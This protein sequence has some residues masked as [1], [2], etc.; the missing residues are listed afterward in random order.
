MSEE[1]KD[2]IVARFSCLCG[3]ALWDST[4]SVNL[5]SFQ[6]G[7]RQRITTRLG[8]EKELG[9]YA[10]HVMCAWRISIGSGILV[11]S[12]DRNEPRAKCLELREEF[13]WTQPHGTLC[14]E[15]MEM[16]I[17]NVCP[18]RVQAV[19]GDDMGGLRLSLEGGVLLEVFPDNSRDD[20]HWR[21]FR[22]GSR[23][24]HLVFRGRV[25]E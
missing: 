17:N 11:A 19:S 16:F 25:L 1:L 18:L 9:E 14:D 8:D 7:E 10:F 6:F 22:P 4:R 20:E 21:L 12:G 3:K 24:P 23:L 13:D 2:R 15:K 5:Q